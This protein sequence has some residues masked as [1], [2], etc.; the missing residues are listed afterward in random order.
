MNIKIDIDDLFKK[1]FDIKSSSLNGHDVILISPQAYPKWTNQD[2]IFRSSMW[3]KEADGTYT[4]ISAGFPKFFNLGEAPNIIPDPVKLTNTSIV[5]KLDGS[6]LTVTNYD[7][8]LIH[9]TRGTFDASKLDNGYEIDI[10]RTKYPRAF[11]NQWINNNEYSLIYEWLSDEQKIIIGYPDC[12]DIR[13]VGCVKHSDYSLVSQNDLD[14]IAIKIGVK[15]PKRFEFSDL[16]TLITEIKALKGEEGCCI[17]FNNDQDIKKVKSDWYLVLHA[18]K[19]ECSLEKILDIFIEFDQPNYS[20]FYT[21]ILNR[22]DYECAQMAMPYISQICDVKQQ[23]RS[24]VDGMHRFV[25]GLSNLQTRKD[26]ALKIIEAYGQ[27]N[28][29]GFVFLILDNKPF[30]KEVYKKLY[31]QCLKK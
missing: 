13:L 14:D 24:I 21:Q 1:E 30:D 4:L 28:R 29:A 9:R 6:L 5:E 25:A 8:N 23:V 16:N 11:F 15:R 27:T 10:L 22:F 18:F 19:A 17:Y 20:D 31:W 3:A 7:H 26:K 12:P 2:L